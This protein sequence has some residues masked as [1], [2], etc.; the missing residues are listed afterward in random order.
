MWL[1]VGS[2]TMD[3]RAGSQPSSQLGFEFSRANVPSVASVELAA[4][5]A[6]AAQ[7]GEEPARDA[8]LAHALELALRARFGP[9]HGALRL[10]LTDNRRT[11]VSLR[12]E[13]APELLEVRLH[14]MFLQAGP[15]VWSALGEYLVSGDRAAASCIAAYIE[16][17]REHIRRPERRTIA[18]TAGGKHHDLGEICQAINSRYFGGKADVSIT[19]A[20][21]QAGR[22]SALRRSIKL[23]SYTS[24]DR[25]IRVHPALDAAFVPRYFV[26][27]IVFH[28]LL[29]HILPPKAQGSRRELHGPAFLAREREFEEYEAALR[30]E[31]E[32][33]KKLLRGRTAR[34]KARAAKKP[35]VER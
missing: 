7:A 9:A 19:W 11:M 17:H 4:H 24:R 1:P 6:R 31:R 27:Y 5:R 16:K 2:G 22:P 33:L 34:A 10:T 13:K 15:E 3:S 28:E 35:H 29:H 23:G 32:N 26:E 20:R 25:L 21:D 8:E 14:H 12:K 30:W 18:L